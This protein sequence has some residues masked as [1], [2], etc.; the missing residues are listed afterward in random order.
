MAMLALVQVQGAALSGVVRRAGTDMPVARA[1]VLVAP[2]ASV[3][4]GVRMATTDERGRFSV[5]NLPDG[6]YRVWAEQEDYVRSVPVDATIESG[7]A[8]RSLTIPMVPT[9]VIVGRVLDGTAEPLARVYV[10]AEGG[11]G[12]W[13][14]Q[15]N[16]LGE[17]RLFGLPPGA[18]VV[19]AAPYLPPRIEEGTY[20]RP[21]PP[22][23]FS[24]GEGQFMIPL[25]RL[26]QAGELIDPR[27]LAGAGRI[28]VFSP[29]TADADSAV[30]LEVRP[31]ETM[32]GVDFV[33]P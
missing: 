22:G 4:D 9:G 16:D 33:L 25:A 7:A 32:M 6:V 11:A 27:A 19:S 24:R 10:R 3:A 23:P 29:G 2:H 17:Y 18:Y 31:G 14:A 21:T 30:P 28:R 15:T 13:E 26:L 8:D 1:R 12:V 5:S 20:V